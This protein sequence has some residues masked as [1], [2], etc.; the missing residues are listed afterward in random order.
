MNSWKAQATLV[1]RNF[2]TGHFQNMGIDIR[3]AEI[4]IF[5]QII[6]HRGGFQY[7]GELGPWSGRILSYGRLGHDFY[8]GDAYGAL[9]VAGP[10]AVTAGIPSADDQYLLRCV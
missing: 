10:Y 5:W 1:H 6:R 8:L 9:P 3:L 7:D 2:L 4:F